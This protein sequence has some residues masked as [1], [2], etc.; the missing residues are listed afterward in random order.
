LLHGAGAIASNRECGRPPSGVKAEAGA[1]GRRAAS[2]RH[3]GLR[4][5]FL[6]GQSAGVRPD[7]RKRSLARLDAL[8]AATELR[9]LNLPGFRLHS[10][11]GEQAGRWAI[12]VSGPWRITFGWSEDGDAYRVDLE[13]YH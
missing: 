3:K 7:L 5:L 2:F 1:A 9:Q 10:L 4:D 13:Q 6:K 8:D 12:D 11:K